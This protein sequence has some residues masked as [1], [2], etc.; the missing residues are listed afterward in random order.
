MR[1]WGSLS[2]AE[3]RTALEAMRETH[4]RQ[5]EIEVYRRRDGKAL[6]SLTSRLMGGSIQGDT[7][8]SPVTYLEC[9]LFDDAD[10][11]TLDWSHGEHRAF[12]VRVVDARFI[13]GWTTGC[14]GMRSTARSG[15]SP[16]PT[17]WST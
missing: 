4:H 8:R 2:K 10:K 13:T 6:A 1:P 5:V 15:T 17:R 14:A 7:S 16:A 11:P 3:T 12:D 9:D